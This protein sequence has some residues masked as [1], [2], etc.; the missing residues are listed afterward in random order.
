MRRHDDS[1]AIQQRVNSLI[2]AWNELIQASTERGKGLE[3]AKDILKFNE[4]VDKV[5]AW[6][7]DKEMLVSAG[8]M[9]RDYEHC[10]AL[11]KKVNDVEGVSVRSCQGQ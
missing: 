8:D 4:E 2:Q 1:V 9:G 10:L 3:E 6:I 7:R 5:Q 11:Q